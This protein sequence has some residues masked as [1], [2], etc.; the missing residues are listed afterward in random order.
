MTVNQVA[1]LYIDPRGP[2]PKL[3]GA[4]MCWDAERERERERER[5]A[6]LRRAMAC[7]RASSLRPLDD[8]SQ[9]VPTGRREDPRC[10]RSRVR[11]LFQEGHLVGHSE[12]EQAV[13]LSSA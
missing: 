9:L 5:R 1:A 11:R 12:T 7:H 8:S 3:L 10:A 2:Y 13:I 4:E 6:H